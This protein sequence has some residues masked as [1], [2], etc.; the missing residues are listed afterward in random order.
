T[1]RDEGPSLSTEVEAAAPGA[2]LNLADLRERL[3]D[4]AELIEIIL[5]KFHET[6]RGLVAD[7]K[8]AVEARDRDRIEL[9]AHTLKGSAATASAERLQAAAWTLEQAARSNDLA[10]VDAQFERIE[11]ESRQVQ[12]MLERAST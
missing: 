8:V 9:L 1:P 2:I 7:L 6:Q 11:D 5:R 12:A 3:E 4:D 10:E